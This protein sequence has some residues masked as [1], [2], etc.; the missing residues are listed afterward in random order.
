MTSRS[1]P[2]VTALRSG[3]SGDRSSRWSGQVAFPGGHV[4]RGETD[5]QAVARECMEGVGIDL[6]SAAHYR[7]VGCISDRVV[8]RAE[9]G[10]LCVRCLVYEQ[11][12][13]Q[14]SLRLA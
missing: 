9:K 5:Q 12:C 3:S 2:R 1:E 14:E 7:F 6:Q 11:L 4:E 13:A 10:S 8:N